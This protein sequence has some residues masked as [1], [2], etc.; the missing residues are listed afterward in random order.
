MD[1]YWIWGEYP[2]NEIHTI[3]R[4]RKKVNLLRCKVSIANT[5]IS[6]EHSASVVGNLATVPREIIVDSFR[7]SC[8]LV[9]SPPKTT[10]A[11]GSRNSP[12]NSKRNADN[13]RIETKVLVR[14][15]LAGWRNSMNRFKQT[16]N[17]GIKQISK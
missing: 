5:S 13:S 10:M 17:V 9:R 16:Q 7:K 6:S 1:K 8:K 12:R 2:E 4:R 3:W 11:F 14:V 15:E